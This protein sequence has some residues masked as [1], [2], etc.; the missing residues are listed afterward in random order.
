MF[1]KFD[2]KYD[3]FI[4]FLISWLTTAN[5]KAKEFVYKHML[6]IG[7]VLAGIV[8]A[9]FTVLGYVFIAYIFAKVFQAVM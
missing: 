1:N 5:K 3:K 7:I 8:S 2:V 9:V 6:F 4:T